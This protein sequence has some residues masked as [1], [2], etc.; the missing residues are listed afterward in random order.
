MNVKNSQVTGEIG[1]NHRITMIRTK[2]NAGSWHSLAVPGA[3]GTITMEIVEVG[4]RNNSYTE[5]QIQ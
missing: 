3:A 5:N 1:R 4:A 2:V